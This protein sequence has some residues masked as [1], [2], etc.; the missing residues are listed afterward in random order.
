ML[1]TVL[2]KRHAWIEQP[3]SNPA[4]FVPTKSHV[5]NGTYCLC[6]SVWKWYPEDS[7]YGRYIPKRT[8]VAFPA[9]F[10]KGDPAG[11]AMAGH[12][13]TS[14]KV[15]TRNDFDNIIDD[16]LR[17]AVQSPQLQAKN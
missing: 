13:P 14:A 6:F 10:N 17:T 2:R 15:A 9:R 4:M 12:G 8:P 16:A 11:A 3:K 5:S 7:R 1:S